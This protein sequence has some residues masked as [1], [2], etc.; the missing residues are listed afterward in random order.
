MDLTMD[1]NILLSLVNMKLRDQFSDLDDL[2]S[3]YDIAKKDLEEA[4]GKVGYKYS[5]DNRQ[6]I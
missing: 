2:C 5:E 3:Y 4:L 6:F 1:P